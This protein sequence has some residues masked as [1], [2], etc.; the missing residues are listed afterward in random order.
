M[1][2]KTAQTTSSILMVRPQRFF[3]NPETAVSNAFQQQAGQAEA[4]DLERQALKEFDDMVSTLRENGIEVIVKQDSPEPPTPDSIFP[5]NWVMFHPL[6]KVS[7]FPMEAVSRRNERRMDFIDDL[8]ENFKITELDDWSDYEKREKY[9]EGTG[10]MVFDHENRICYAC[11]STRTD[12][13][14]LNE[15]CQA[16]GYEVEGFNAFDKNGKRIYHT[17]VL[18]C[19]GKKLVVLCTEAVWHPAERER[20][21]ARIKDTGKELLEIS[22]KQM[23]QFAGNMLQLTN[24]QGEEL[25][26]MSGRAFG[27]LEQHQVKAIEKHCRIVH[28]PLTTIENLGGGSARCMMAEVFLPPK[29]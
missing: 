26:V 24:S 9:L 25:L 4:K 19:V 16:T 23:N 28:T 12:A 29:Q 20:L 27:S 8:R 15:F 2:H 11:L 10:S 1:A 3:Y 14:L 17:N 6:G 13:D 5:N 7:L 21:T 18:M 22:L